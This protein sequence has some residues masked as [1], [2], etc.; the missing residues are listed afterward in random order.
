MMVDV[1][2][3]KSDEEKA[4]RLKSI[5]KYSNAAIVSK[6]L[7]G[8]VTSWNPAAEQIFGYTQ[9]EM[10]GE[11]I[12]KLIPHDLYHE[13]EM[14]LQKL[15]S[16][17]MIEHMETTRITKYGNLIDVSLT[18]SPVKDD[19][20]KII[21]VSKIAR[22]ISNVKRAERIIKESDERFRMAVEA[23]NLGT[24]EFDPHTQDLIWSKECR[25]IYGL[26]ND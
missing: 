6:T 13:E 19:K 20:G 14:I 12:I 24:W 10:I 1:T 9:E 5:V 22:D 17:E 7:N 3:Q 21:G 26:N 15:R 4:A 25:K 2:R 11:P 16:G 18:V 23:T 8:I